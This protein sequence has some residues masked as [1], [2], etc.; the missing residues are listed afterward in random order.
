MKRAMTLVLLLGS[1]ARAEETGAAFLKVNP[2]VQGE[3]LGGLNP[4]AVRGAQAMGVNP[5]NLSHDARAEFTSGFATMLG[6]S[7]YGTVGISARRG[8]RMTVGAHV[9]Y[10]TS[11]KLEGRDANGNATRDFSGTDMAGGVSAAWGD[12][13]KGV[14]AT[15]KGVR[16]AI[17]D[18][19]SNTAVALDVGGRMRAGN[20]AWGAAA[21]NLGGK[22]KFQGGEEALPVIYS[23]GAS[24]P[25]GGG[26][27]GLGG[28]SQVA[29]ET[30]GN[31]GLEYGLGKA[32]LRVGYRSGGGEDLA[33]KSRKGS[34]QALGGLT[35]GIG[36][37][38]NDWRLDYAVSQAAVEY[39][40]SHRAA[41][42]YRWGG[43]EPEI[44]APR[45]KR[46]RR[47]SNASGVKTGSRRAYDPAP[48]QKS[49]AKK[50]KTWVY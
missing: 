31:V 1:A 38:V 19:K 32:S 3:A 41:V 48:V 37:Q 44:R 13:R 5:A 8:E 4:A 39:G 25:L 35:G 12:E 2:S 24:V 27:R 6:E 22:L 33:K 29:G 34:E 10:L 14:G 46:V 43:E 18:L 28:I 17:G 50:R 40:M 47:V 45:E 21:L 36:L 42:G 11:G 15:V 7:A 23:L 49:P 9:A 30:I 26:L 20:V 16:Q